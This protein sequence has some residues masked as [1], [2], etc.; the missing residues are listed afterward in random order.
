MSR[1]ASI[2][3]VR[4][5]RPDSHPTSRQRCAKKD[6]GRIDH[7]QLI[8]VFAL[9]GC[10]TESDFVSIDVASDQFEMKAL[11]MPLMFWRWATASSGR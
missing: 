1:V 5:L 2:R 3:C 8:R 9:A 11:E 6:R 7:D 10:A 4:H